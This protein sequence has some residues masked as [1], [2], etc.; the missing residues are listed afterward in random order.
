MAF[1]TSVHSFD[2]TNRIL[3]EGQDEALFLCPAKKTRAMRAAFSLVT[4]AATQVTNN[5]APEFFSFLTSNAANRSGQQAYVREAKPITSGFASE[6][7][8]AKR[9]R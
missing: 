2:N 4:V 3:L 6:V 7:G 5:Q 9:I 8:P 1:T